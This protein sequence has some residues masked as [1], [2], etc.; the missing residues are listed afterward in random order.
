[1]NESIARSPA[2]RENTSRNT[3]NV[4]ERLLLSCEEGPILDIPCGEG[5]FTQRLLSRKQEVYSAD[6]INILKADNPNFRIADMNQLLPFESDFFQSVV[7]IDGIEHIERPFDFI[8]ECR[9]I[10][11]KHGVLILSTPNISSLRSRW[12]WFLTGHHNKCKTP[13][14]EQNPNPLHHINMISFPEMRY[15]L[16][17]NG[18]QIT[19]VT[20]NRIK[21]VNYLY[22]PWIPL[23]Y[24][25]T[26]LVYRREE[27]DVLQRERNREILKQTFSLPVLLGETLIVKAIKKSDP[28]I[29]NTL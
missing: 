22:L 4:A 27:K 13:L 21:P 3:H 24:I 12:R 9:R 16:H 8:R 7:C 1:M 26:S 18:F 15:L 11:I 29:G 25:A 23:S 2:I 6:V 19:T 10:L 20:T 14:N 28:S 17:T 5:A